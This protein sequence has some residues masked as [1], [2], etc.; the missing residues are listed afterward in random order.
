MTR[1]H[2]LILAVAAAYFGLAGAGTYSVITLTEK[3]P[4]QRIQEAFNAFPN[5]TIKT[6]AKTLASLQNQ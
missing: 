6:E 4:Q 5:F 1:K 3:S 2:L